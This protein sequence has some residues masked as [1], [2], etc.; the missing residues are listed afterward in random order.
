MDPLGILLVVVA[1]AGGT[2]WVAFASRLARRRA[3]NLVASLDQL[4]T[5]LAG[6]KEELLRLE[7]S[8]E[9]WRSTVAEALQQATAVGDG[10]SPSNAPNSGAAPPVMS[11]PD[12]GPGWRLEA[13]LPL[14]QKVGWWQE[15]IE[16]RKHLA[17]ADIGVGGLIPHLYF[18]NEDLDDDN[19]GLEY[20][21]GGAI[22]AANIYAMSLDSF[23]N[24]F[25]EPSPN[26][27]I[28][29]PGGLE[30]GLFQFSGYPSKS[31]VHLVRLGAPDWDLPQKRR[32]LTRVGVRKSEDPFGDTVLFPSAKTQ[33]M[34][35]EALLVRK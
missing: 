1:L 32:T 12:T 30:T 28:G 16:P 2:A 15:S 26:V 11:A 6:E 13:E 19:F 20:V 31:P 23:V 8:L 35:G 22:Q 33:R 27:L 5:S 10:A 4:N 18:D 21:H 29:Q 17:T 9:E 34:L 14:R 3:V 25:D 24:V 7:H